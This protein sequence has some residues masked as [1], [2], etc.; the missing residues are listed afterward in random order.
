MDLPNQKQH[1]IS[2]SGR[3]VLNVP[4][5][6]DSQDQHL[7]WRVTI[8]DPKGS[9]LFKDDS[10]FVA[11]LNVYWY[12][13]N[14]DRVWLKNSDNGKIYFWELDNTAKWQRTLWDKETRAS[15]VPPPELSNDYWRKKN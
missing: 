14:N 7:Y 11:N 8:S 10:P 5:E 1:F 2:P 9:V 3:Y 6:R 12:W 13:D 15:L 4:I